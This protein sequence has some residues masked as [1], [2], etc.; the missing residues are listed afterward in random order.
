MLIYF[1]K[2]KVPC[3]YGHSLPDGELEIQTIRSA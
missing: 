2:R 1:V 3:T